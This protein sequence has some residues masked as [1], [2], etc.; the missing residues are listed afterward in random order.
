[1]SLRMA[2]LGLL[3]GKGPASGYS[4]SKDFQDT[5]SHVWSARHSQVYPE[6]G[7]MAEQGLVTVEAAGPRGRKAYAVTDAGRAEL[8]RWLTEEEPGRAVR[9]EVALRAFLLPLLDVRRGLELTRGEAAY[10]R[11]RYRRLDELRAMLEDMPGD[12]FGRYAAEL[13]ARVSRA[14]AEWADW[15]SDQLLAEEAGSRRGDDHR[16]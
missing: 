4:L 1:M 15:A 11:E 2:L 5:L 16:T 12:G 9:S 7:R 10:Q 13:G 14:M 3:I 6:L 8:E